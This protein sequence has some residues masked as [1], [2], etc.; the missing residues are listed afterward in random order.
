MIAHHLVDETKQCCIRAL[1]GNQSTVVLEMA[2]MG[3]LLWIDNKYV[4]L[5]N[6]DRNKMLLK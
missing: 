4:L 1:Y 5:N 6:L 3:D 2:S